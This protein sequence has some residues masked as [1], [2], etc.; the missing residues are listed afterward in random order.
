MGQA[1]TVKDTQKT[2]ISVRVHRWLD[3][4]TNKSGNM[5]RRLHTRTKS[6]NERIESNVNQMTTVTQ[7]FKSSINDEYGKCDSVFPC[8]KCGPEYI[9][10][11]CDQW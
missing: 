8:V 2:N 3:Q 7:N 6:A 9:C 5:Y 10:T 11:C 1:T 4:S